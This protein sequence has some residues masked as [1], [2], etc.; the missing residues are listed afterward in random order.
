MWKTFRMESLGK[1]MQKLLRTVCFCFSCILIIV[2]VFRV[3]FFLYTVVYSPY[4]LNVYTRIFLKWCAD[5]QRLYSQLDAMQFALRFVYWNANTIPCRYGI[6][7]IQHFV[8]LYNEI[9][10]MQYI[11]FGFCLFYLLFT[12]FWWRCQ[13]Y[14]A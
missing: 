3:G 11:L 10:C 12:P 9:A 4:T 8:R 13:C 6:S 14:N 7:T 1:C 5:V 2:I